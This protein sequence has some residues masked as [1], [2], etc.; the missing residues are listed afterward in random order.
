MR[1]RDGGRRLRLSGLAVACFVLV[2]GRAQASPPLDPA[3]PTC[4]EHLQEAKPEEQRLC[5]GKL[6]EAGPAATAAIPALSNLLNHS[7]GATD[8]LV[9]AAALDVLRS[10]GHRAA[11]AA[12]TLS[13]LLPYR[14]KL[15]TGRDKLLVIRLRAYI[16][17]TLNEI[18]FPASALPA[19]LDTLAHVDERLMSLEVGA[20]A[21]AVGSLGPRGCEFAPY[22]LDT[23]T[24]RL[25][26]E[27][28]SLE[29]YEPQFPPQ[30]ATTIQLEAVR[31]LARVCSAADRQVLAALQELAE[32][33]GQSELDPRVV[34]EAKSA[35][36]L[37]LTRHGERR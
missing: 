9:L 16:M 13:R 28:F 36:K 25:S 10:L 26:E 5:L 27:E 37:I 14:C 29:R 19:L 22:L 6:R 24:Q 1:S 33:R 8:H 3:V 23:L 20:A 4:V 7:D 35:R 34:Q 21:R 15:Y 31:S 17:V 30:E 12:E 11:P 2:A 18:G 32:D